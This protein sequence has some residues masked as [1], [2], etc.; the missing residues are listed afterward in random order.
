M[1]LLKLIALDEDD[2]NVVSAQLQDALLRIDD[3]AFMPKER[4]FAVLLNRFDWLNAEMEHASNGSGYER[5]QCILRFEKVG[6]AQFKNISLSDGKRVLELLAIHFYAREAPG[7]YVTLIFAG[8][9]AVRLEVDCIEAELRDL[10]PS[11]KTPRKPQHPDDEAQ[12]KS[13]S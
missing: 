2:L 6:Q 11:W 13:V 8:G 1:T 12:K 7:G 5:R 4:R 3:M 9:G 10:G